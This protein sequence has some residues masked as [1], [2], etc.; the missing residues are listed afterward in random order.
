MENTQ[1]VLNLKFN[2]V[3]DNM[4]Y[5]HKVARKYMTGYYAYFAKDAAQNSI[6]KALEKI[7]LY[8]ESNSKFTTWAFALVR[9]TCLDMQRKK[10]FFP[11]KD[12]E[13]DNTIVDLTFI[14]QNL[15]EKT[16]FKLLR[17]AIFKL[18]DRD[19]QLILL[20]IKFNCSSKE[21]SKFTRIPEKNINTFV[22]RAKTNLKKILDSGGFEMF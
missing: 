10:Q 1:N 7:E 12:G 20:K 3:A 15:D 5:F 21:M 6:L 8:N 19:K 17:T 13:L 11:T 22:L 18:N 14:D 2:L 9:N 4:E 16:K